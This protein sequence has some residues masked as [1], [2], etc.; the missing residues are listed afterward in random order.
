MKKVIFA[1]LISAL[2]GCVLTG[3]DPET[4]KSLIDYQ[5]ENYSSGELMDIT[6][7]DENGDMVDYYNQESPWSYSFKIDVP[8]DGEMVF[9]GIMASSLKGTIFTAIFVDGAIRD[10]CIADYFSESSCFY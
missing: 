3:L 8:G 9:L 4:E 10:S 6:I 1:L 5:A 7:M 2:A